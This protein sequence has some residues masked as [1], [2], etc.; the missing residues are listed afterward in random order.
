MNSVLVK[1]SVSVCFVYLFS[2]PIAGKA[3][4]MDQKNV[5]NLNMKPSKGANMLPL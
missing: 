4:E 2:V 1:K 5:Q 3:M